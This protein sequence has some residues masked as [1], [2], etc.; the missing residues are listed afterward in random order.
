MLKGSLRFALLLVA[1]RAPELAR[2]DDLPPINQPATAETFPGKLIWAD[3]FT[4]DPAA[5]RTFYTGL[6]GWTSSTVERNGKPY[7]VLS[8]G[9]RPIAGIAPLNLRFK[10]ASQ[11]RWVRFISVPDVPQ[12]VSQVTA[13]GG[14][15]IFPARDLPQRGV[16]AVLSD[17]EGAVI[18]VMHSSSGD[19]GEYMAEPGDWVWE[20]L[21]SANPTRASRFY[22]GLFGYQIEPDGRVDRADSFIIASGGYARAS[23][24]QVPARPGAYPAWLSFVRVDHL[25][26]AIA[27]AV[28]LGGRL[29]AQPKPPHPDSRIAIVADPLGAAIGLVELFDEPAAGA[30]P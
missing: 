9:D 14:H 3:L 27:R 10:A 17:R 6:F 25:D 30:A 13:A 7:Y 5:A 1:V 2:A 16:Q 23:L 12:A 8:N 18:G 22:R 20:E 24:A 26:A 11:G 21:F 29:L 19:P 15:V 28:A 4:A